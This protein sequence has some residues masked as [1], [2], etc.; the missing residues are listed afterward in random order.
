M[1]L[2]RDAEPDELHQL[3]VPDNTLPSPLGRLPGFHA[4]DRQGAGEI[5]FGLADCVSEDE[6]HR[7]RIG[8][9]AALLV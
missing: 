4:P 1:V 9:L 6:K 8:L 5:L 3:V 7:V 2:A